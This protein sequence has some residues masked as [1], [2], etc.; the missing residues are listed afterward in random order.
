M[1]GDPLQVMRM[2]LVSL[3]AVLFIYRIGRYRFVRFN[4]EHTGLSAIALILLWGLAMPDVIKIVLMCVFALLGIVFL[5]RW[6]LGSRAD[7]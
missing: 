4:R 1:R 2:L 7:C 6:I 5:I 3:I